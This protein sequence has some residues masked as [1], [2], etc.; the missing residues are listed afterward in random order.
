MFVYVRVPP[1]NPMNER[2]PSLGP[3]PS[4]PKWATN[5]KPLHILQKFFQKRELKFDKIWV[6]R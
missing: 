3:R 5:Y 1:N 4:L 6:C 2:A